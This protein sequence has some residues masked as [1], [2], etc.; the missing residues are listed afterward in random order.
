MI[1]Y[2]EKLATNLPINVWSGNNN[3]GLAKAMDTFKNLKRGMIVNWHG[4]NYQNSKCK[5]Y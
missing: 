3:D 4:N 5:L 1:Y 2:F